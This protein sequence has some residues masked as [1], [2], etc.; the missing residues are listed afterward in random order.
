MILRAGLSLVAI[1]MLSACAAP[2]SPRATP[3]ADEA[4]T[5]VTTPDCAPGTVTI[6]FAGDRMRMTTASRH[7]TLHETPT[8]HGMLFVAEDDPHT[9]F[10]SEDG[11]AL[12]MVRGKHYATCRMD[13]PKPYR[14]SG[15]EP[16]WLLDLHFDGPGLRFS[17]ARGDIRVKLPTPEAVRSGTRTRYAG[18]A[19]GTPLIVDISEQRCLDSMSGMPYPDTVQVRHGDQRF[20]G[21]G[22][23]PASL[24]QGG[25]WLVEDIAGRGLID[26]SHVTIDFGEDGRLSGQASC[27]SYVGGYQIG[28]ETLRIPLAMTTMMHCAPALMQ[29]EE[30]FLSLLR[31][32]RWFEFDADGA[33]ILVTESHERLIA[34]RA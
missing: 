25:E 26:A 28:G 8:A 5:F 21:C 13:R 6:G 31:Q 32:V 20:I 12:V 33:L 24:L 15:N 10:W 18:H 11:S 4:L 1:L 27:N 2:P 23:D 17:T 7:Y 29:Q 14:A 16:G 22:G 30:H 9:S 34:R 19:D 3:V